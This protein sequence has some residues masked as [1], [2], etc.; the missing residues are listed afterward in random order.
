M[1]DQ[2]IRLNVVLQ[3]RICNWRGYSWPV[4]R[5]AISRSVARHPSRLSFAYTR[6]AARVRRLAIARQIWTFGR[7]QAM[8]RLRLPGRR[9]RVPTAFVRSSS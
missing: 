7:A 2:A 8:D 1:A 9:G 3:G 6:S 5:R 4:G